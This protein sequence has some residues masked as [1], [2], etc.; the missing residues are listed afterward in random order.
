MGL[1]SVESHHGQRGLPSA[2]DI[3]DLILRI[4][5][6]DWHVSDDFA[7]SAISFPQ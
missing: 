1:A 6:Q 3:S 7:I 4:E 2:S 5:S